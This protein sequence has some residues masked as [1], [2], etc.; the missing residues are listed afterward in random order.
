MVKV[1]DSDGKS[2]T[3]ESNDLKVDDV[4]I[5]SQKSENAN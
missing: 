3:I 2:T 5:I 4:V 1:L